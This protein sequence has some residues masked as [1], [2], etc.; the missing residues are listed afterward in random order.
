MKV[1]G[2]QDPQYSLYMMNPILYNPA[3]AGTA[4]YYQVRFNSRFQWAGL[5]DAPIT[6]SICAYGPH[7]KKDMG[8]GGSAYNDVAGPTSR[9]GVNGI[10]GYNILITSDIHLS[11][12]VQ[13]GLIQYKVD[14]TKISLH[15]SG[16]P[17]LQDAVYSKLVPDA[18][19]GFYLW[20]PQF[21]VGFSATQLLNNK[22][23]LSNQDIGLNKLKSHFYLTGGYYRNI[24]R[25]W[26]V[27]P[28]IVLKKVW[29]APF[30]FEI[31]AKAIYQKTFWG[32]LAFR[33]QDAISAILG[34]TYDKKYYF[35]YSFDLPLSD[36]RKYSAGSHEI[37]LGVNFDSIKKLSRR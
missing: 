5:K 30:Q 10:Y 17:V 28:G 4:P 37:V 1:H 21:N 12:G 8:Y 22:V 19:L 14:G 35:A 6:N 27:E 25:D 15:D 33:T 26:A 2:Q 11:M 31:Y 3:L 23:K 34:Y 32:G 18:S 36:I 16:D 13:A 9:I 24:N 20:S 29:P 7:S